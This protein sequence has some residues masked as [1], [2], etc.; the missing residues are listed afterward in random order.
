M[1]SVYGANSDTVGSP[2]PK[3]QSGDVSNPMRR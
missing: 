1:T 3:I 2:D